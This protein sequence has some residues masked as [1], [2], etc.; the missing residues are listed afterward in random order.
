MMLYAKGDA[1]VYPMHGAG[2]IEDFEIK[3]IDGICRSYCVL[4]IPIGDLTIMLEA[5]A[6]ENVNLRKVLPSGDIARVMDDVV[7]MPAQPSGDNWNKRYK[8]NLEKIKSGCLSDAAMVFRNLYCR[9]KQRGLSSAEKK[10]LSNVK[11]IMLSEIML[12]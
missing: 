10:M 8:D 7:K 2:I 6:M 12:S 9:E 1:V 11:K 3:T 5:S 4:R